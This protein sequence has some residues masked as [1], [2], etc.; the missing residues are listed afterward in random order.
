MSVSLPTQSKGISK[1]NVSDPY[2][3]NEDCTS[4]SSQDGLRSTGVPL[5]TARTGE[6]VSR[7]SSFHKLDDLHGWL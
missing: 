6:D 7:S 3:R 2:L 1:K 5:L 4:H